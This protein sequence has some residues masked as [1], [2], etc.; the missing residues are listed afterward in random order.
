M[1]EA[2]FPAQAGETALKQVRQ[3]FA[4]RP[5]TSMAPQGTLMDEDRR[6]V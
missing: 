6:A 2:V 1:A 3:T 4:K 5:L